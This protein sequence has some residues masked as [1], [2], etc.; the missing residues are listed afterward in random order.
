MLLPLTVTY[1]FNAFRKIGATIQYT[2]IIT[3]NGRRKP[4]IRTGFQP[5]SKTPFKRKPLIVIEVTANNK[6]VNITLGK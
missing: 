5:L 6:A 3:G 4:F 1:L 2:I